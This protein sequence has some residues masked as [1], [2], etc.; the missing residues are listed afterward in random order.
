MSINYTKDGVSRDDYFK[1][2]DA[3][4]VIGEMML[5][6]TGYKPGP[7]IPISL[8]CPK[9]LILS[10]FQILSEFIDTLDNILRVQEHQIDG[11]FTFTPIQEL[12]EPI[13]GS[14]TKYKNWEG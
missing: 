14:S 3:I 5:N 8:A 9:G 11:S 7:Y 1:I 2:R 6:D 13:S 12:E 10:K 4:Y